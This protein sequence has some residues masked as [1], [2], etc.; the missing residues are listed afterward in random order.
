MTREDLLPTSATSDPAVDSFPTPWILTKAT[1]P[2]K[3]RFE[4]GDDEDGVTMTVPKHAI[5]QISTS[6][7][8]GWYPADWKRRSRP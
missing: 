1:F 6:K 5:N 8:T 7:S 4:P 3:Y 2:L